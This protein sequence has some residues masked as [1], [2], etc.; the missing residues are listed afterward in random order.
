MG[1]FSRT[2]E[3]DY[4]TMLKCWRKQGRHSFCPEHQGPSTPE[5]PTRALGQLCVSSFHVP[6]SL[7]SRSTRFDP[8]CKFRFASF[9]ITYKCEKSID[10]ISIHEQPSGTLMQRFPFAP[11]S[12]FCWNGNG[13]DIALPPLKQNATSYEIRI[14]RSSTAMQEDLT[15]EWETAKEEKEAF[16]CRQY[17][18]IGVPRETLKSHVVK[19]S[20]P[21]RCMHT[22]L[23]DPTDVEEPAPGVFSFHEKHLNQHPQAEHIAL[24]AVFNQ[25]QLRD[26]SWTL[27]RKCLITQ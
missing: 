3:K 16:F 21:P 18:S 27:E 25:D 9:V 14:F 6:G 11:F 12:I 26:V 17:L 4:C 20:E 19:Y 5:M 10:S 8:G 13:F 22:D 1:E 23:I 24:H 2:M 15:L 7:K